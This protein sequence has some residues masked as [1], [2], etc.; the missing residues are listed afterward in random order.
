MI[1]DNFNLVLGRHNICYLWGMLPVLIIVYPASILLV[2]IKILEGY[3]VVETFVSFLFGQDKGGDVISILLG[4]FVLFLSL[5]CGT[6]TF[7][8]PIGTV[9]LK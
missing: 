7:I 5:H 9:Q 8:S 2:R 4:S 6:V 3:R 1:Y